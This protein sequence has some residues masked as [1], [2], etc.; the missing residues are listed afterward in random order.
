[1]NVLYKFMFLSLNILTIAGLTAFSANRPRHPVEGK[2]SERHCVRDLAH[3]A[4]HS[5]R[6]GNRCEKI[7]A[8]P[9]LE[10]L[11]VNVWG[12]SCRSLMVGAG[13]RVGAFENDRQGPRIGVRGRLWW[14][15]VSEKSPQLLSGSLKD[16]KP[17]V[18]SSFT[19]SSASFAELKLPKYRR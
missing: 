2:R 4:F 14:L 11:R 7:P 19:R 12:C 17:F 3:C 15:P 10:P 13:P 9:G 18:L 5:D 1:M 16:V 8:N 6:A